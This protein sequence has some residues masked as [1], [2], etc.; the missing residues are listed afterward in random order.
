MATD[1]KRDYYEVLG[2]SRDASKEDLR[3]AYRRL[4]RR[5]HPDVSKD[6]DAEER[7]KEVNEAYQVLNDDDRRAQYDQFG[8]AGLEPEWRGRLWG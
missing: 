1:T 3:S 8:H 5:Y 6:D 2:V 7:F 4:A